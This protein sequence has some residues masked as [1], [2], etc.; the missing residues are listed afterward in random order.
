[1]NRGKYRYRTALR[2]Y[3]PEHVASWIPKG[4]EDCGEHEWYTADEETWRCY[5]CEVGLT[6]HVPWDDRELAAREHEAEAMR[7][8]AGI[9]DRSSVSHEPT[10]F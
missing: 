1:M 8:R 3:L 10:A 9:Q 2:E 7:I 4:R 5:H 6:H